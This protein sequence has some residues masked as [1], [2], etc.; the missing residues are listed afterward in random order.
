M[1]KL[2]LNTLKKIDTK[3]IKNNLNDYIEKLEKRKT[4][5]RNVDIGQE[6]YTPPELVNRLIKMSEIDGGAVSKWIMG[7]NILEPT[8]GYGNI[9]NKL[10][11]VIIQ[12]K[13]NNAAID[14]VEFAKDSR[15]YLMNNIVVEPF[16]KLQKTTDF[17][18][19]VPSNQYD[20]IYM[21]P[22]FHLKKTTNIKYKK[23]YYDYD[24][25]VKLN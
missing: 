12:N 23:D 18:E 15:E 4:E 10:I 9:V 6:Y 19:Y 5:K 14:M 1:T 11:P 20:Y 24:L 25:V 13:Y 22:P 21:N 7:P 8:A 17:L 16:I 2:P 3:N